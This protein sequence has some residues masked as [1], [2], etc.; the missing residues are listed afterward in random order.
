MEW[1]DRLE[2]GD[3]YY[4]GDVLSWVM[5]EYTLVVSGWLLFRN[6]AILLLSLPIDMLPFIDLYY[7]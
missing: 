1:V 2:G 3:G 7:C 6:A 4:R 5:S